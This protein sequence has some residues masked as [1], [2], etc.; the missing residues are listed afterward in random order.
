M[1]QIIEHDDASPTTGAAFK[2]ANLQAG[3]ARMELSNQWFARPRDE[4]YTSL[5]DLLGYTRARYEASE[6]FRLD[7]RDLEI[8]APE[9]RTRE[10][11]HKLA[12]GLPNGAE[13]IPTHWAFGQV[14]SLSGAPA[15]YLRTLPSPIVADAL[16]WGLRQNRT[17][18]QVKAFYQPDG[19][20][21]LMAVTG[22]DYGRI[23]DYEVVEAVAQLTHNGGSHWKVPGTMDWRTRIYDPHAPVTK[24]STTL[25]ASDRDV[26]MFLVDDTRPIQVGV[27]NGEPDLMFRG[28]YA[29]N[30]EVGNKTMGLATFYLRALCLNRIMWGVEQF[31]EVSIRH[32]KYAP[33]RFLQELRPALRSY[34]EGSTASVV[35]GVEAAKAAKVADDDSEALEWLNAR[36]VSRKRA[37]D[38]LDTVERE[39]GHKARSVWDMAQGVTAVARLEHNTDTRLDL[40]LTARKMLDKVAVAA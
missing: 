21:E 14:A 31:Q 13:V 18:E 37:R 17:V 3:T 27:V 10:D 19:S 26:F 2:V 34:A 36:N 24:E 12:M 32:S 15:S 16:T 38:I 30:S 29:W 35:A 7:N 4:R 23:P 9:I 1:T 39:E 28:F 5:A 40:E 11:T 6:T 8:I 33:D 25:F 20:R 22:P